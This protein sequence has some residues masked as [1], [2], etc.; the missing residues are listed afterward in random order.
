VTFQEPILE[1][2]RLTIKEAAA[3]LGISQ[4]TVRRRI[5]AGKLP[6]QREQAVGGFTYKVGVEQPIGSTVGKA[7]QVDSHSP[8]EMIKEQAATIAALQAEKTVLTPPVCE[9]HSARRWFSSVR[10][11]VE[12]AFA[13][14]C[15]SFGLHYLSDIH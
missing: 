2:L 7:I 1:P 14:L 6:T 9:R 4:Q 13:N 8:L 5:H 12:T 11:A 3:A 10:Q 15:A